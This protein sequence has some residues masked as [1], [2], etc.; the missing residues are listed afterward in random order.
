M[1][2]FRTEN[3]PSDHPKIRFGNTGILL[4]NLGTPDGYDYLSLRRYLSQFLSDK[5][6]I[7]YPRWLW[8]PLLQ[9]VIL[10]KRPFTSGK[11]YKEIWN[12]Q[13]DESPLLTI[14]RDQ[15]D[16]LE[17]RIATNFGTNYMVEFCMRYGR[18][19]IAETV[20]HLLESGCNRLLFFPLYPQYS[21]TTTAT[22]CDDLWRHLLKVKWLPS[23]RT[24]AP[25]FDSSVYI[26]ALTNSIQATFQR[27]EP[28]PDMLLLSFHGLPKRYLLE[29]DPYHCHCQKTARLLKAS[30]GENFGPV[31]VAFQSRFG[32]EE[33]LKPYTV[34]EVAHLAQEGV[35]NLAVA[36][37][38]FAA[39]CIETLEEINGEIKEAFIEAGGENFVY[40]P[41]LN[42][43]PDHIDMLYALIVENLNG[44]SSAN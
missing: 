22:A 7:D 28:R 17:K 40:V 23:I 13:F 24:V 35:K 19:S 38:G 16:S 25:Y 39:D 4:V 30:L 41:A 31:G 8:Q 14:T 2:T 44:W 33:W 26:Q 12:H 18:P 10:S 15:K 34:E 27:V 9:I 6:V 42:S 1:N 29:G 11:A 21:A 36:A 43:S 5:R 3:L 32:S 37:P 20:D